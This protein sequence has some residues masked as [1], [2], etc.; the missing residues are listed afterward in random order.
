MGS[1]SAQKVPEI[2]MTNF[3][4]LN[5]YLGSDFLYLSHTE[6][7]FIFEGEKYTT[8]EN[9]SDVEDGDG[10]IAF[11]GEYGNCIHFEVEGSKI[12]EIGWAK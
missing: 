10:Y 12:K 9:H 3:S 6:N 4:E 1:H 2:A 7:S 11:N 8:S 5:K